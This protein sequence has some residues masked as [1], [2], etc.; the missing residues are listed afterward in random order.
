RSDLSPDV[1]LAL[2]RI[3]RGERKT[4]EPLQLPRDATAFKQNGLARSLGRMRG[5]DRRDHDLIESFQRSFRRYSAVFHPLQRSA[6]RAG[7]YFAL[8][9]QLSCAAAAL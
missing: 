3:S 8:A 9:V 6:K 2:L 5:E 4:I 1:V 7:K